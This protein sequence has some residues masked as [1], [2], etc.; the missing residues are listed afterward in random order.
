MNDRGEA[1]PVAHPSPGGAR[2][3]R[4][5]SPTTTRARD[6]WY[7]RLA[8]EARNVAIV[9]VIGLLALAALVGA[10]IVVTAIAVR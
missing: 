8:I 7:W 3:V 5:H 10:V 2:P 9:I 4:R 1:P 6:A